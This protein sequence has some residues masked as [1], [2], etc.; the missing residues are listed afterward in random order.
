MTIYTTDQ[1]AFQVRT[2]ADDTTPPFKVSTDG[3]IHMTGAASLAGGL[4][5]T[6]ATSL[7]AGKFN[8]GSAATV[9][10]PAHTSGTSVGGTGWN[11]F[12]KVFDVND[13]ALWIPCRTSAF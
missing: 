10:V 5:V 6:G 13:Q 11:A 9:V 1:Y 3:T 4:V 7:G 8:F 2:S 12:I